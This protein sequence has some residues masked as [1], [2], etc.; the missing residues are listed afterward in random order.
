LEEIL[1]WSCFSYLTADK[2]GLY[3]AVVNVFAQAKAEFE[4]HMRPAQVKSRLGDSGNDYETAQVEA[5]LQQL[6]AWGNLQSYQDRADVASLADFYRKSL[7]YQM[8]AAGEAAHASTLTFAERLQQQAKLDARALERIAERAGQ[9]EN[10]AR[11]LRQKPGDVDSI[12]VLTTVRSIC[13]DTDELTSR[14]QSF[15]RWLHEQTE[16]GRTDL[17]AFLTYKERLIEYL[18]QFVG[19]LIT[20]GS[21]IAK[22]LNSV[23]DAEYSELARLTA[24]EQLGDPRVG[25]E[26]SHE[27]RI[28][29]ARR[30]WLQQLIGLRGWFSRSGGN[31]AQLEQLRAA[32]RNAIPR[33]LQLAAQMNERQSGRSD[34]VA[35]LYSL[36]GRFLACR[37]DAQAH[38]LYR[39][40]FALAP[41]RHLRVDQQTID[42]RDQDPISADTRW[43]DAEPVEFS[44][45]LRKTGRESGAAPNRRVVDR[46]KQRAAAARR[47][48]TEA[49]RIDSSRETL[50]ALGRRR[51]SEISELDA[52][53]FH[54]MMELIELCVPREAI[55]PSAIDQFER[56]ATATSRDGSVRIVV[57]PVDDGRRV[58]C[59]ATDAGDVSLPDM[60]VEVTRAT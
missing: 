52:D 43:Q 7:L 8:T 30:K 25:E 51:L 12:I 50:I 13:E 6:E 23:S 27:Q 42:A 22:R 48:A 3:R 37:D 47:L 33:L 34:R 28:D 24:E 17:Q 35:D 53:A 20:R 46:T 38:R 40:A 58:A 19:E 2:A 39:A 31:V 56:E 14:A 41:A 54:L 55:N 57:Q 5:A 1:D 60:R 32:A 9:L 15:F 11:Q 26:E 16:S 36:A 29:V 18:Q 45:Q 10:L 59:L 4:L 44:P 21:T 49:G